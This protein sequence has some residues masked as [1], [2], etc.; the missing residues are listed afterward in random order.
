M[1]TFDDYERVF[2]PG[3]PMELP[4]FLVGRDEKLTDLSR[5]IRRPGQHP[6]VIGD[7]GVGKTS[8][9]LQAFQDH[10]VRNIWITCNSHHT[11]SSLAKAIL[12][13]LGQSID[14]KEVVSENNTE[15]EISGKVMGMGG[16]KKG[17][18]G[19][20]ITELGWSAVEIDPW[21]LYNELR[22]IDKTV[23]VL[24]E[25]DTVQGAGSDVH[26]GVAELIKT[27]ADNSRACD[28]RIVLVGIAARAADWLAGHESI[29]RS[30]REIH[31]RPLTDEQVQAF[32]ALAENALGF[33]FKD[34][35]REAIVSNSIGFPYYV[36]MIGLEC[37]DAMIDRNPAARVVEEEDYHRALKKAFSHA[38][39]SQ[40]QKYKSSLHGLSEIE[41]TVIRELV[42][43]SRYGRA[44]RRKLLERVAFHGRVNSAVAEEALSKLLSPAGPLY[45][46][47]TKDEIRFREPL[48]A[49]FVRSYILPFP[50]R[51]IATESRDQLRLFLED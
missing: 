21:R 47:E 41:V 42:S 15:Y 33:R 18:G 39:R 19:R 10:S 6:I 32:L 30:A 37:L 25:Y 34:N 5:A 40:L 4:G 1:F 20:R 38:F 12:K 11:F 17:S 23:I 13:E 9:A 36:H 44:R 26:R 31:L 35:V 51:F 3:A 7:R 46:A 8:V 24:D 49:P 2:R 28:S 14:T 22:E 29:H 16:G 45:H 48:M 50:Q 43:E 27:L